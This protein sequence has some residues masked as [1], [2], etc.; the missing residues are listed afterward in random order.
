VGTFGIALYGISRYGDDVQPQFD[1]TPFTATPVDYSSVLVDWKSPA[2]TWDAVR[3]IR[4]RYGWAVNESDGEILFE[5][6]HAATR[7][8]D[9][10]VVGGHWLYY[11]VFIYASGAWHRAGV[12]STLMPKNN[13]YTDLL[14]SL[15]PEYY[16]IDVLS[17]NA[18]TDDSNVV[19]PFLL[20][21]LSIFGFGFDIVKSYYDSNRYTN[22]A[23]RTHYGNVA[24][25]ATQFGIQYEASSPAY[26]FRERVRDAATLGRQKG[27]LAQIRALISETTG[28]D[29][30]LSI[31]PNLML[32]NDQASFDHPSYAQWDPA[33]NYATGTRVKFGNYLYAA[34]SSGAYGQPQAP[35][36]AQTS[37]AFWTVVTLGFDPTLVNS[38]GNVAGW[39]QVSYTTGVTPTPYSSTA[40][41]GTN[42]VEIG[43]GV[44]STT[45]STIR[46]ANAM[47]VRNV[48]SGAVTATMGMR[49]VARL[50]TQ[51]TMDPQ[52]PVLW[53]IPIPYPYQP[54]STYT[55]YLPG[56]LVTYHGRAYRALTAIP[57]VGTVSGYGS[58][59]YGSGPY[60]GAAGTPASPPAD[61]AVAN[62]QW[63]PLG[64]DGRVQLCLSGYTQAFSGGTVQAYPYIE[65]YDSHGSL[66]TTLSSDALPAFNYFDSFT[67]NW[68]DWVSRTMDVG[69]ATWTESVGQWSS[70]GYDGGVAYPV[71]PARSLAAF[72]GQANGTV[73]VTFDTSPSA[74]TQ[75]GVVFRMQDT[76]NYW[77]AGRTALYRLS[78]TS[79]AVPTIAATFPYSTACADGDR[80]T[81]AFSGANITVQINGIQVVSVT[82]AT[83]ST[84]TGVGMV[85]E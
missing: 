60:G 34:G 23:M 57:S 50:K 48:N 41:A 32:S 9:Q 62:A 55:S 70:G 46:N 49:S 31:G 35:T 14:Y 6:G 67:Q 2:G 43:V 33:V 84:A 4:N 53:G 51:S 11:A 21:F 27:T 52:Q 56:D 28:Y 20:P 8:V 72:T 29:T 71:G 26:L 59:G 16:K 64:Y 78:G 58:G 13:G 74:S 22:D 45:D 5:S 1:I 3:L 44:Q 61:N 17:N 69:G 18:V 38:N 76:S 47:V 7:F 30:D 39:E 66:I 83:L 68:V 79:P 40:T 75:Q 25:M 73:S 85:V 12:T 42:G 82:D 63:E 80:V 54:W 10:N 37:N 24:Q 65:F 15:V 77:R 36:G 81:A 19:N